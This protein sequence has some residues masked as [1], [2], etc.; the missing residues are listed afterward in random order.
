MAGCVLLPGDL[1][2]RRSRSRKVVSSVHDAPSR[3]NGCCSKADATSLSSSPCR[4]SL[5]WAGR[6]PPATRTSPSPDWF[7]LSAG[8]GRTPV[9][10]ATYV[11]ETTDSEVDDSSHQMRVFVRVR[12][13]MR[14]S[15]EGGV[16][17]IDDLQPALLVD[18]GKPGQLGSVSLSNAKFTCHRVFQK[19]GHTQIYQVVGSPQVRAHHVPKPLRVRLHQQGSTNRAL[20]EEEL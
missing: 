13:L 10:T 6:T 5:L 1:P 9:E 2:A 17:K 7:D 15:R 4:G 12:P 20:L 3:P 19:E 11:G 16:D 14:R 8:H 18:P